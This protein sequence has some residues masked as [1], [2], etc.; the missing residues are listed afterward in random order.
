MKL[1]S[2]DRRTKCLG[3]CS[4]HA[5]EVVSIHKPIRN[6][7][8]R[9]PQFPVVLIC[10][11]AVHLS[12]QVDIYDAYYLVSAHLNQTVTV[13]PKSDTTHP[14]IHRTELGEPGTPNP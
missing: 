3:C 1:R 8:N 7:T 9:R 5:V 10:Q 2:Q 6:I 12:K 4:G 11:E 14:K 13:R